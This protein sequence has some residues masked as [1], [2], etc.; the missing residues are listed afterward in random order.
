[1][2]RRACVAGLLKM[3]E[4]GIL[5]MRL[6]T[7]VAARRIHVEEAFLEQLRKFVTR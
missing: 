2:T 6:S 3:T 4:R 7:R 1:M 5:V